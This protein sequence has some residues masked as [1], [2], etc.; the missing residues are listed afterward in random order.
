MEVGKVGKIYE[1][2]FCYYVTR[3]KCDLDK[4]NST[5]KH[6]SRINGDKIP[7]ETLEKKSDKYVCKPCYYSTC[8]KH[9]FDKHCSTRKHKSRINGDKIPDE[10]LEKSEKSEKSEMMECSCCN[11]V[12][13]SKKDYEKH[14][15]T[16][17]H[18]KLIS[19]TVPENE[20]GLTV[21][22]MFMEFMKCH[23]VLQNTI[24]E[25]AKANTTITTT[26]TNNS[27]NTN[28]SNNNQQFNLQFF[29]NETCKDAMNIDDFIKT[30]NV[31]ID[32]FETTGKLG[33]VEGITRIILNGLK[34]VDTTKR[35]IHCTDVKRETV[36][37]KNQDAWEKE[38]KEKEKL[39]HAVNQVARMNLS[40]LPKWQQENPESEVLDTKQHDE[41][42][43]LA[44]TALGG[45]GEKEE[46]QYIDKIMKNVMKEVTVK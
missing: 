16:K 40:Q 6:K 26:T 18:I 37:I 12:T 46:D 11:Y 13:K 15:L 39:K 41:Y 45:L 27:H 35:P 21:K 10:T 28:N 19:E 34:Q 20:E 29:L 8:D 38:N 17:K 7:D 24:V 5:R 31:T 14:L 30:L 23:D 22:T 33:Y 36:Y 42:I 4:H 32:D 9:D 43:K 44:K 3:N 25:L 1:C 2:K